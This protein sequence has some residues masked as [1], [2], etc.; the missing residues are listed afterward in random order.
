MEHLLT[1]GL[2]LPRLAAKRKL[3]L[4]LLL[5]LLLLLAFPAPPQR[6]G[7]GGGAGGGGRRGGGGGRGG[8]ED[9]M[10]RTE[11]YVRGVRGGRKRANTRHTRAHSITGTQP[12]PHVT[13]SNYVGPDTSGLCFRDR[14]P[15]TKSETQILAERKFTYCACQATKPQPSR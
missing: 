10:W 3:R 1:L 9:R 7:G 15:K 4:V 8:R 11:G 5:V 6:G 13:S 2:F 14:K 12:H